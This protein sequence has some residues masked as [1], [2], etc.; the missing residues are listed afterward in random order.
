MKLEQ[1]R[2]HHAEVPAAAAYSPEEIGMLFRACRGRGAVGQD[3][4]GAEQIVECQP[5]GARQVA[6]AAAECQAAYASGRE[7]ATWRGQPEGMCR[8]VVGTPGAATFDAHRFVRRVDVDA[9]H[10]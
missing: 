1:E 9:L 5:V 6:Y 2:R 3:Q 10:A 7:E 8:M 4:V